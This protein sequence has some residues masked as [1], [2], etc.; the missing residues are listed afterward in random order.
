[1]KRIILIALTLLCVSCAPSHHTPVPENTYQ[2]L[3][4]SQ[5]VQDFKKTLTETDECSSTNGLHWFAETCLDKN[6]YDCCIQHD[7]DY[8]EGSKYGITKEMADYELYQCI[9]D[10]GHPVVARIVYRAVWA[11]GG[12]SYQE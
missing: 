3:E 2:R 10:S 8:R 1:M 6:W 4:S 12:S 11:L 9:T 7:F 5:A